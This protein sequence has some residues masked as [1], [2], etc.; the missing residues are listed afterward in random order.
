MLCES[1]ENQSKVVIQ[2]TR[3]AYPVLLGIFN[4]EF[5]KHYNEC[6]VIKSIFLYIVKYF[7]FLQTVVVLEGTL[8][9]S[10]RVMENANARDHSAQAPPLKKKKP[11][12]C[13]AQRA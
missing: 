6:K 12:K 3:F 4:L 13:F 2:K 11:V 10:A 7:A 5:Y 9:V 8:L 1:P